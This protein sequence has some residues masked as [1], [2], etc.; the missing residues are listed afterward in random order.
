MTSGYY[1]M[2]DRPAD[3]YI[4]ITQ[5]QSD[6]KTDLTVALRPDRENEAYP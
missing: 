6:T 2:Q 1:L 3:S 4:R 5:C